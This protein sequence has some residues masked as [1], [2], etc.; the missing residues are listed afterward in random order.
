MRASTLED[1]PDCALPEPILDDV[2]FSARLE[3][4]TVMFSIFTGLLPDVD[5]PEP[6]P[7]VPTAEIDAFTKEND[8]HTPELTPKPGAPSPPSAP[9]APPGADITVT[10]EPE[11]S[12][13]A[14][15]SDAETLRSLFSPSVR[16][17]T[18]LCEI[19]SGLGT[20]T[21]TPERTTV[22][23]VLFKLIPFVVELPTIVM[24]SPR[25]ISELP[26]QEHK[27][28]ELR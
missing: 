4:A 17:R 18:V 13:P 24:E 5:V 21:E 22:R 16:R 6:M 12:T 1:P 3:F 11:H 23:F 15:R 27:T 20:T 19:T 7:G 28:D 2:G 25:G 14:Q 26:L 8:M 10:F 9:T